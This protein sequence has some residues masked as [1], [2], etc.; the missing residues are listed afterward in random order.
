MQL[1]TPK[2]VVRPTEQLNWD[3]WIPPGITRLRGADVPSYNQSTNVLEEYMMDE[4]GPREAGMHNCMHAKRTRSIYTT[5]INWSSWYDVDHHELGEYTLTAPYAIGEWWNE[6]TFLGVTGGSCSNQFGDFWS[7]T[8]GLKN[9]ASYDGT[10][11]LIIPDPPNVQDLVSQSITAMLPGLK[12]ISNVSLINSL[13]E[14][15][16]FRSLPHSLKNIPK[17]IRSTAE[18]LGIISQKRKLSKAKTLRN[19]L[20]MAA[21]G[22]LQAEFNILPLLSDIS[23][24]STA[25]QTVRSRLRQLVQDANRPIKRYHSFDLGDYYDDAGSDSWTMNKPAWLVQNPSANRYTSYTVRRFTAIMEF[26][27]SLPSWVTEDSLMGALLDLVGVNLNPRIIWN[28]IPWSFTIDWLAN[29]N[30][31]LDNWRTRN[32]EPIVDIR[33]FCWSTHARRV[34]N[35]SVT[36]SSNYPAVEL[37]DDVYK[38]VVPERSALYAQLVTSGLSPKEFSLAAALGLS[39]R[40]RP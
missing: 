40:S 37:V 34:V 6:P 12:P 33:G 36:T 25:I 29:V 38:R 22:Y 27:Y 35:T 11:G 32:I 7:P 21:D 13:I 4:S 16:D 10:S 31:W 18:L 17:L 39:R 1:R 30:S 23:A 26:S 14:L 19:I 15:K 3:Q 5:G 8:T 24:V 20:R 28:A 9:L 2:I